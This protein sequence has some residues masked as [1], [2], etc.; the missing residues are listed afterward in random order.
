MIRMNNLITHNTWYW[1]D[2][3]FF[4][5]SYIIKVNFRVFQKLLK[6]SF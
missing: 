2:V 5:R 1:D 6:V 3:K 4:N